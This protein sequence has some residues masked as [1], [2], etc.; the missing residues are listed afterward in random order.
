M[1][2]LS[3]FLLALFFFFYQDEA[4]LVI[5]TDGWIYGVGSPP[6]T[7]FRAS[8]FALVTDRPSCPPPVLTA[9]D[10]TR[11]HRRDS[12]FHVDKNQAIS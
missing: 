3:L 12:L 5:E 7:R 10:R 4:G 11:L 6:F 9:D 1:L 8:S 2:S